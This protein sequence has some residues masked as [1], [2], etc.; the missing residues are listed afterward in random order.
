MRYTVP[1]SAV[2]VT[3]STSWKAILLS[4]EKAADDRKDSSRKNASSLPTTPV[5]ASIMV[6]AFK[7]QD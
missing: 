2:R 4:A 7:G 3:L 1:T 5:F 6:M